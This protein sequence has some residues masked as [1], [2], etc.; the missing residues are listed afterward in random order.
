MTA[1][2]EVRLLEDLQRG[3]F[4]L[5]EVRGRWGLERLAFPSLYV[6][7]QAAERRTGPTHYCLRLQCD[8]YPTQAPLGVFWDITTD[9]V[10]P[11]NRWPRRDDENVTRVF[12]TDWRGPNG[13][14][15]YLP[16]DRSGNGH[17]DWQYSPYF[18]RPD[19][20]ISLYVTA[21]YAHL[22]SSHYIGANAA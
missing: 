16:C 11:P 9:S 21:V 4:V 7:V 3:P 19:S 8:G 17:P 2:S 10:L 12:R 1:T 22:N 13:P 5:G 18:W 14:A 20:N 6:R 15:L